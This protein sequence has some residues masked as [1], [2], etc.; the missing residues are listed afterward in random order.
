MASIKEHP[1]IS[2]TNF[3]MVLDKQFEKNPTVEMLSLI[4]LGH[5]PH[6]CF[7]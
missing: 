1:F 4:Y 2:C 3:S 7:R 5:I 6:L